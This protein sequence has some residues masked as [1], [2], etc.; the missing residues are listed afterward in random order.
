MDRP[1][2]VLI[3]EDSEE[4]CLLL[5]DVLARGGYGVTYRRVET[6]EGGLDSAEVVVALGPWVGEFMKQHGVR[7]PFAVKELFQEWLTNHF[8]DRKEKILNR[9][10]DLRG[11]KLNDANFNTRMRG[12]GVFADQFSAIGRTRAGA[13]LPQYA[14]GARIG[15]KNV[16]DHPH[17]G[18]FT[19]TIGADESVN[20]AF[21]NRQRKAIHRS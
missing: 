19:G 7:L 20:G 14:D 6:A 11:G 3:V 9:I 15:I 8:P 1:L 18:G 16:G 4:D 5:N 21:G 13:L 17:G 12:Q 2:R 10:R